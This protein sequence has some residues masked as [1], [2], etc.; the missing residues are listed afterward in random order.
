V[1]TDQKGGKS[2]K[3]DRYWSVM[4]VGD[5]GRVIPFRHFKALTIAAGLVLVLSLAA[6]IVLGVRYAH[7]YQEIAQLQKTLQETRAQSAKLRDEKDLYLTQLIALKK[8]QTPK[9][10]ATIAAAEQPASDKSAPP[11]VQPE[12]KEQAVPARQAQE[13]VKKAAPAPQVKWSADI[14][15][16]GVSYDSRQQILKAEFRLYNTSRPK[17]ALAGRAVV[18]FKEQD[19]PPVQWAIVPT[20]PLSG[21]RPVGNAG[22]FFKIN[23]Y[24][25][26]YFR[27]LC[28]KNSPRYNFVT[29]FIFSEQGDLIASQDLAF[30]V[31]YATPAA[32]KPAEPS[33]KPGAVEPP[34]SSVNEQKPVLVQ[35]QAAPAAAPPPGP[36]GA[37]SKSPGPAAPPPASPPAPESNGPEPISPVK[38]PAKVQPAKTEGSTTAIPA[39]EAKPAPEGGK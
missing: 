2:F 12:K 4:L 20:V 3:R 26:E 28:R 5:H 36:D 18:I 16:L 25:T 35:P 33:P 17:K 32:V 30:N 1:Q 34:D 29:V 38:G 7:Q 10:P 23:N 9:P 13:P 19:D 27:A 11:A 24:Q 8:Q 39:A 14:R 15:R 21:G 22:K 37:E 6:L 31:D